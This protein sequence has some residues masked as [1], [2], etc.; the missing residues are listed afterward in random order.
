MRYLYK[1]ARHQPAGDYAYIPADP[2]DVRLVVEVK[3]AATVDSDRAASWCGRQTLRELSASGYAPSGE[4]LWQVDRHGRLEEPAGDAPWFLAPADLPAV[5]PAFV[6][7]AALVAA[8]EAVDA[9]AL[10][11]GLPAAAGPDGLLEPPWRPYCLFRSDAYAYDAA[12]DAVR[13]ITGRQLVKV[14][15]EDGIVGDPSDVRQFHRCRRGPYLS[16]TPLPPRL[17]VGVRDAAALERHPSRRERPGILVTAPFLARGGAEHTLYET[18]RALG[19]DVDFAFATLAPHRP[20]LGDRRDDFRALGCPVYSLGDLVHPAAMAGALGSLLDAH[21]FNVVYNLSGNTL[22]YEFL[23][24]LKSERSGLRVIDHLY[25]HRIGYIDRYD[26]PALLDWLD[27]CVAENRRVAEALGKR[28]WPAERVPVIWPCGRRRDAFPDDPEETRRTLR[29]ELGIEDET[30]VFLTA[31]RMHS[32][33]RPLDLVALAE[34][35][36]DLGVLF[37]IAGGGDLER[38]VDDAIAAADAPV[39]RLPFRTDVPDLIAAADVGCLV[40][41]YEG[42]PVF[43]IECLQAGRPFLGTDVGEMGVVLRSTGAGLVVAE[44]G[45]L[46]ALEDRVRRLADGAERAEL[47]RRAAEAGHQFDVETCAERYRE[48]FLGRT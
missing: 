36:R 39:R 9:V 25:D 20:E 17:A 31:A 47:A 45:D 14:V 41:D 42:L 15:S 43:M 2:Q 5:Y 22:F 16:P 35:V 23:P 10:G 26:D 46:A 44:P 18:L 30:V 27:A 11:E 3:L 4:R 6:E 48:A 37:L 33:K 13:P 29:R 34:R 24:R 21:G 32:Q 38:E 1:L 28:G 19:N 8:A 7:S 12:V 40:S